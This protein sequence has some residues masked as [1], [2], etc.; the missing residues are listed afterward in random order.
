M[1]KEKFFTFNIKRTRQNKYKI[2]KKNV[3]QVLCGGVRNHRRK[4]K[5][6]NR[7][8][9]KEQKINQDIKND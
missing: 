3:T 9:S 6:E 4:K 7:H 1:S 2:K 5:K 8:K